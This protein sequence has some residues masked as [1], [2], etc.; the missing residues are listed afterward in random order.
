[1]RPAT[2][3]AQVAERELSLEISSRAEKCVL[4]QQN[5][6]RLWWQK[7]DV[8]VAGEEMSQKGSRRS[9]IRRLE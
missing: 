1:M 5:A 7:R 9:R 3:K 2:L 6:G 4:C 8:G